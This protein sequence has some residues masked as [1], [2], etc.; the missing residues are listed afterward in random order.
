MASF[1][2]NIDKEKE[3][4]LRGTP[5]ACQKVCIEESRIHLNAET[6]YGGCKGPQFR[7]ECRINNDHRPKVKTVAQLTSQQADE[8]KESKIQVR[9]I[10]VNRDAELTELLRKVHEPSGQSE[11][12]R[13]KFH[14]EKQPHE[15]LMR[16]IPTGVLY[17]YA[18]YATEMEQQVNKLTCKKISKLML[19][20]PKYV[21]E[22]L[23]IFGKCIKC[24]KVFLIQ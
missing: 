21:D 18:E 12:F 16:Q 17:A 1:F 10:Y 14:E 24:R 22:P 8:L 7:C 4:F 23:L 11:R 2:F 6:R 3:E 13:K 5:N 9:L 20:H 19:F 15:A